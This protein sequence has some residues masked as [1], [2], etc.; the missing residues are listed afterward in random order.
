MSVRTIRRYRWWRAALAPKGQDS[1]GPLILGV[2]VAQHRQ[3]DRRNSRL[4]L[5]VTVVVG[6]IVIACVA[7]AIMLLF[8]VDPSVEPAIRP[9]S[10]AR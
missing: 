5:A 9:A 4:A 3:P 2:V 10:S 6:F 8:D 1:P 7:G